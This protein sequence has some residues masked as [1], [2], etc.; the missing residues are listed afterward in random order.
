MQQDINLTAFKL[1]PVEYALVHTDNTH[2][3]FKIDSGALENITSFTQV[4]CKRRLKGGLVCST[5]IFTP[6][7]GIILKHELEKRD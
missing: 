5:P 6:V 1:V 7:L 4:W 2:F 3:A